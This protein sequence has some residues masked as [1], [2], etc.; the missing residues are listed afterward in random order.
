MMLSHLPAELYSMHH[1][2]LLHLRQYG[3]GN[4]TYPHAR[5]S[6]FW[7][8]QKAAVDGA[9]GQPF[10]SETPQPFPMNPFIDTISLN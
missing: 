4:T 3:D 7:I 9:R 8:S 10:L 6:V 2:P 1:L 5:R